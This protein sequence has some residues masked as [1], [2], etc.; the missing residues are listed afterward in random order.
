[1]GVS[2]DHLVIRTFGTIVYSYCMTVSSYLFVETCPKETHISVQTLQLHPQKRLVLHRRREEEVLEPRGVVAVFTSSKYVPDLLSHTTPRSGGPKVQAA[3]EV[4]YVIL[5]DSMLNYSPSFLFAVGHDKALGKSAGQHV[6]F[7][8]ECRSVAFDAAKIAH[9]EAGDLARGLVN[10]HQD[11]L[12]VSFEADAT[13][14][15]R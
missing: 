4:L 3:D 8:P 2:L 12:A 11:I 6:T 10:A 7:L 5:D 9:N 1:M 15:G 13:I 14:K